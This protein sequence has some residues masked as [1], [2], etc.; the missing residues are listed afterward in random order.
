MICGNRSQSQ[1]SSCRLSCTKV[2]FK[3]G[4]SCGNYRGNCSNQVEGKSFKWRKK[5]G[6]TDQWC[7]KKKKI[8]K[9]PKPRHMYLW[10]VICCVVSNWDVQQKEDKWRNHSL[11]IIFMTDDR[12][13]WEKGYCESDDYLC[14]AILGEVFQEKFSAR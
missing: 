5:R 6:N 8:E 13:I 2:G 3:S 7:W 14:F 9:S 1:F 4:Y 12:K 10:L 11:Y